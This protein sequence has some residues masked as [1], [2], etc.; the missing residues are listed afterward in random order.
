M[1]ARKDIYDSFYLNWKINKVFETRLGFDYGELN[2]INN[3]NTNSLKEWYSSL[4]KDEEIPDGPCNM[5]ICT[6]L[7]GMV[8]SY[9]VHTICSI[10]SPQ[11]KELELK[12]K[13]IFNLNPTLK[14]YTI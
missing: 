11:T 6:T 14:T 7:V 9:S 5:R 4:R 1:S 8:A 10:L 12:K 13:T 2:I 3:M